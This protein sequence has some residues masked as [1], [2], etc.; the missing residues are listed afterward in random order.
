MVSSIFVA[1]LEPGN[2]G[3]PNRAT[4]THHPVYSCLPSDLRQRDPLGR[5]DGGVRLPRHGRLP[6]LPDV[7]P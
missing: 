4:R 2:P 6:G 7:A 5:D 1:P 3:G